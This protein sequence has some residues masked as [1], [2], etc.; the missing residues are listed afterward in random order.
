MSK[1]TFP[2]D[3]LEGGVGGKDCK[4]E[5]SWK[6]VSTGISVRQGTSSRNLSTLGAMGVEWS[7]SPSVYSLV[8]QKK[9]YD[10]IMR[11]M[12]TYPEAMSEVAVFSVSKYVLKIFF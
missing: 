12:S 9:D 1:A 3:L 6:E 11:S 2:G 7:V 8:S 4:H 5:C 10:H